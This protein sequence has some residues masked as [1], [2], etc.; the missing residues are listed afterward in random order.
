MK[1]DGNTYG[2][3]LLF[4][5][6]FFLI[7]GNDMGN[8]YGTSIWKYTK[9]FFYGMIWGKIYGLE[10]NNLNREIG[11]SMETMDDPLVNCYRLNIDNG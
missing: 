8:I 11:R 9:C 6:M 7:P 3:K 2:N 4:S 10:R 1:I 5:N